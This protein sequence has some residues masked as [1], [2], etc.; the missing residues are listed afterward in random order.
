MSNLNPLLVMSIAATPPSW[1]DPPLFAGLELTARLVDY[2]QMLDRWIVETNFPEI[3]VTSAASSV[4]WD[5][6]TFMP[7]TRTEVRLVGGMLEIWGNRQDQTAPIRSYMTFVSTIPDMLNAGRHMIFRYP[8]NWET[9]HGQAFRQTVFERFGRRSVI[10][11][12]VAEQLRVDD[13]RSKR[14]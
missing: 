6:A 7:V 10:P 3:V 2:L 8:G 14:P 11:T 9:I 13:R 4:C 12:A 1:I 5:A